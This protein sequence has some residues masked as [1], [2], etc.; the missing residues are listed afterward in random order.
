M[1]KVLAIIVIAMIT[2]V[3]CSEG[4]V[5]LEE[6]LQTST[7]AE[8]T[9]SPSSATAVA[10]TQ[11]STTAQTSE[12]VQTSTPV[13]ISM[14]ITTSETAMSEPPVIIDDGMSQEEIIAHNERAYAY[15]REAAEQNRRMEEEHQ[16][17]LREKEQWAGSRPDF[18]G[19]HYNEFE[20][21]SDT[22]IEQIKELREKVLM[23]RYLRQEAIIKGEIKANAPRLDLDTAKRII[24]ENKSSNNVSD[25]LAEFNK[26][27]K[28]PDVAGGSGVT[29]IE[30]WLDEAGNE[31]IIAIIES[32]GILFSSYDDKGL[33]LN[34]EV[35]FQA[36]RH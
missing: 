25:I 27:Y 6:R 22:Q 24:S 16:A 33:V 9:T 18:P 20:G 3:A 1:K 13:Q 35:L 4:E 7:T 12:P 5:Q 2:L 10:T 21:L 11:A 15:A 32:G 14:S 26:I 17:A 29:V 19:E 34:R 36:S 28:Y 30:Y 8:T 31:K 23:G